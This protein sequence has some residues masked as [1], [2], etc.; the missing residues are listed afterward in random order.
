MM[1]NSNVQLI[2]DNIPTDK[3]NYE[4]VNAR[5]AINSKDPSAKYRRKKLLL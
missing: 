5:R 2:K 4:Y 3:F 1:S